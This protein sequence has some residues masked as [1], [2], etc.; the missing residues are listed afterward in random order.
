MNAHLVSNA[1]LVIIMGTSLKVFPFASMVD[2]IPDKVP[3]VCINRSNPGID[4]QD[5]FLFIEGTMDDSIEKIMDECGWKYPKI[6]RI[7][8]NTEYIK[9]LP[10][11]KDKE[12][13]P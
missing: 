11:E 5:N 10:L 7:I 9:N 8:P 1:D 12:K 6:E 4:R 13:K 3:L 2:L